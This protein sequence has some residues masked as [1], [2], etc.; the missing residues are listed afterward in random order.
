LLALVAAAFVV[1]LLLGVAQVADARPMF[2]RIPTAAERAI[3]E[4]EQQAQRAADEQT[5]LAKQCDDACY[6]AEFARLGPN[7]SPG[8]A[9]LRH[10]DM[11][12]GNWHGINYCQETP[13]AAA[14]AAEA[15]PRLFKG[16]QYHLSFRQLLDAG[17][18]E[19]FECYGQ[20]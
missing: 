17:K 11:K 19:Y 13:A 20:K 1:L 18:Q 5:R 6:K 12:I 2:R 15:T 14:I 16:L 3:A 7:P 4:Q 9:F 10:A 8:A